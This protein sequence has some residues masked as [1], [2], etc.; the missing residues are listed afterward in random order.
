[1]MEGEGGTW[2]VVLN[3]GAKVC[4]YCLYRDLLLYNKEVFIALFRQSHTT[5]NV[6]LKCLIYSVLLF[7]YCY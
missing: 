1:M 6:L 7:I 2:V 3:Y 5:A 4:L